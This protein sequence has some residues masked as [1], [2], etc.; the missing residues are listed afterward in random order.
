MCEQ[1][2]AIPSD[3]G[4][5]HIRAITEPR[6]FEHRFPSAQ[7]VLWELSDGEWHHVLRLSPYRARRKRGMDAAVG[8][9]APL[10]PNWA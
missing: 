9:Q 1:L 3:A 7:P 5:E 8:G 10:F 2:L 4:D 6:L